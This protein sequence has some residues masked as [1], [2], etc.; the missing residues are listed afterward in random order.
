MP[1]ARRL[2]RGWWLAVALL[3]ALPGADPADTVT[4]SATTAAAL[5]NVNLNG[6]R[7]VASVTFANPTGAYTL[8]GTASVLTT[9]QITQTAAATGATSNQI[10][11]PI[12]GNGG[13]GTDLGIT[14]AGGSLKLTGVID[15][16]GWEVTLNGSVT[17]GTLELTNTSSDTPNSISRLTKKRKRAFAYIISYCDSISIKFITCV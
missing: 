6:D 2:A 3:A 8:M 17:N 9:G 10:T 11:T 13:Y 5:G 7:E 16:A 14:V 1:L 12:I 15:A 4:F